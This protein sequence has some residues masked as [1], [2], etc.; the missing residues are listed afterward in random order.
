MIE[1]EVRGFLDEESYGRVV[2]YLQEH[3]TRM[4]EDDKT[5][6]YYEM[7]NGILKV[8]NEHSANR[9]KLSLKI[10]DEFAGM[11]MEE[12]E[13]YLQDEGQVS[14]CRQML[15]ALGYDIK[16]TVY[17][18]RTNF[19]YRGIDFAIKHTPDWGYHFEAEIVVSKAEE[20]LAARKKIDQVCGELGMTPLT[21]EELRDFINTLQ[22]K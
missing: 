19:Y 6:Y 15:R 17:Q 20:G 16:S 11:G 22:A 10:G 8:V 1:V 4:D 13:V 2:R 3:A 5:A 12:C 14:S 7:E 21:P 18:R 9:A